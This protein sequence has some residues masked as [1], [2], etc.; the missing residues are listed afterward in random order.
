MTNSED[1]NAKM[2]ATG[3][4]VI[5]I[6][7]GC[8]DIAGIVDAMEKSK[9]SDK[10]TFINCHTI[11]GLGSKV[12]GTA[13]AHGAAFGK[14]DV[15]RMKVANGFNPE[16]HFVISEKVREFFA[17][18]PARGDSYVQSWDKLVAD[19]EATHPDLGA[20]FRK[21]VSGE[22]SGW[23]ELIP[24]E[25]PTGPTATRASS[26]LVFNPIAEKIDSF[27]VGTADLSPSVHMIWPGKEDFQNV[28]PS[29]DAFPIP[30]LTWISQPNIKTTCGINGTY[31]GRYIHYGVREHVMAAVSNGIAAYNPGTIIP[32][33]SSFFMFYLYAAPAVRMGKWDVT[34]DCERIFHLTQLTCRR[35]PA[36]PGDP[37]RHARLHRYG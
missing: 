21:R 32:V 14:D 29:Q 7:D 20:R 26:G 2:A 36:P 22:V 11:I 28:R 37:R 17:G 27:M 13:D 34:T 3:W 1:I 10:P 8:F 23:E 30:S 6:P 24:K 25:F 35:P 31:A 9:Q 19:Y 5:D 12:E 4:N 15:A 16:E 18:L 33:T